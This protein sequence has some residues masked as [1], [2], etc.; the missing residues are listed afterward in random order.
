M[1]EVIKDCLA[2]FGGAMIVGLLVIAIMMLWELLKDQI[3]MAIYRH[4]RKHRF[5]KDPIA[6]CYCKDCV[7]YSIAF[8]RCST[9]G[10]CMRDNDFC[11]LATPNKR[12]PEKKEK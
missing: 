9:Y 7:Y 3:N 2:L 8:E 4:K 5:D 10:R 6:E 1:H 11:S 12:D